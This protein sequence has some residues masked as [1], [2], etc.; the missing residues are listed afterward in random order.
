MK[1]KLYALA[2]AL[3]LATGL[4]CASGPTATTGGDGPSAPVS[5]AP[6]P[7][8]AV[9]RVGQV[10]HMAEEF[11][12]EVTKYDLT[13]TAAKVYA[14]EPGTYGSKPRNGE[15]LVLT[16]SVVVSDVA[17]DDTTYVSD[18]DFKFVSPDGMVYDSGWTSGF[19]D[20]LSANELRK[21]QKAMGKVVF[22]LPKGLW[23]TG[24]VQY[25][26]N[27]FDDQATC[28]WKLA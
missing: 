26:A 3:V 15:F 25:A 7:S 8:P 28:F 10:V 1:K 13:V 17:A 20:T 6:A 24:Q 19:G 18:S 22:D 27:T 5:V 11:L 16:V 21:G 23:K 14:K 9:Y 12:G 2:A 4:A